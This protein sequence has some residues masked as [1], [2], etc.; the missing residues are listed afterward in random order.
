ML[1]DHRVASYDNFLVT[2]DLNSETS[3]MAVCEFCKTY[4]DQNLAKDSTCFKNSSKPTCV[5]L[6]LTNFPMLFQHSQTIENDLSDFH[7]L[8]L[9]VLNVFKTHSPRLKPNIT[10]TIAET[11]KV[12]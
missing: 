6:I 10:E 2:E 12:L 11:I 5:D 3:E 7:K 1:G 8:T 4:N 9:I